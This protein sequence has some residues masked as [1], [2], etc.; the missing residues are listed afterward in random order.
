[1]MTTTKSKTFKREPRVD[2]LGRYRPIG[3]AS[4]A[5]AAAMVSA[6]TQGA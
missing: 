5:A 1:M 4:V 3:I 6:Q 2:L